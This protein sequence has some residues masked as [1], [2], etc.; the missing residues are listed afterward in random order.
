MTDSRPRMLLVVA[1]VLAAVIVGAA[2][3]I[4]WTV[5]GRT[6]PLGTVPTAAAVGGGQVDRD[7]VM[8]MARLMACQQTALALVKP[9]DATRKT[10]TD[11]R[12]AHHDAH[13]GKITEDEMRRIWRVTLRAWE[14]QDPDLGQARDA[15]VANCRE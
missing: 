15:M 11:H 5:A 13:D 9:A 7:V 6:D 4:A 12:N 2:L 8:E 14:T 10:W 1:T 3:L